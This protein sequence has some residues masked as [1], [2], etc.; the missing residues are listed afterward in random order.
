YGCALRSI[1]ERVTKWHCVLDRLPCKLTPV[2]L[3]RTADG[4]IAWHDDGW[5][6]LADC[7]W[8]EL[9]TRDD[10]ESY[11]LS[12]VSGLSPSHLPPQGPI[13]AP[14]AQQEVWAAGVTYFRSR[15]ARMEES[16]RAGGGTFYDR[17]YSAD[18]PEL[19]FKATPHR[20]VGPDAPVHIRADSKWNVPEPEL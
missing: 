7:T 5:Y 2:K 6:S 13:L 15:T 3:F 9:T 16:E 12:A 18:R 17:V 19:F 1:L 8:N 14:V 10:L 20:V 11:L 4:C